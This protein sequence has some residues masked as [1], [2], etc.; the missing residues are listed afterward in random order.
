MR[1]QDDLELLEKRNRSM[2]FLLS[3]NV[4]PNFRNLRFAHRERAVTFLPRESRDVWKGP[5]NPARR[6]RLQFANKF[7]ERFVLPQLRQDVNVINGSVND[8]RD[9]ILFANRPTE[10]LMN[11]GTDRR[12]EPRLPVLCRKDNVIQKIA[13]GGTHG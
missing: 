10:V 2:M 9:S 13:I 8:Q 4:T 7:G 6:V 1:M 3:L 12:R 5:R 11:P